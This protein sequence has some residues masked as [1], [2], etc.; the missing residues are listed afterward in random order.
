MATNNIR[1][2]APG[3]GKIFDDKLGSDSYMNKRTICV[4]T[5][6]QENPK[7]LQKKFELNIKD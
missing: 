3:N 4:L 2:Q 6:I 5:Y 7:V 1:W